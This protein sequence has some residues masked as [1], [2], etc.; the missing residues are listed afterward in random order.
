MS[1]TSFLE[2]FSL[3][4]GEALAEREQSFVELRYGIASGE[5]YTLEQVAQVFSLS[6]ER[7]RQVLERSLRKIKHRGRRDLKQGKTTG[8]CAA[9]LGYAEQM[10]KPDEQGDPERIMMFAL[11]ELPYLP[12]QTYAFPL[13]LSLL[14]NEADAKPIMTELMRIHAEATAGQ[15]HHAKVEKLARECTRLLSDTLWPRHIQKG[16][17]RLHNFIDTHLERTV[18][19]DSSGNAGSFLSQ[20]MNRE[21]AYRSQLEMQML[22][23]LEAAEEVEWYQEQPF[24][25]TEEAYGAKRTCRPDI[26]FVL[27]DGRGAIAEVNLWTHMALQKNLI[28]YETLRIFCV[29][30]GLGLLIT[31]GR[32]TFQQIKQHPIPLT[33]Q[34]ALLD[35]ITQSQTKSLT[36]KEYQAIR[37]QYAASWMDFLAIIRANKLIWSLQPFTLKKSDR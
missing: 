1:D 28:K 2:L 19:A 3:A 22:Q 11:E 34:R 32:K 30:N 25:V 13:L 37:D 21:I 20:K 12:Q 6:R 18:P 26:L 15:R 29:K 36:W 8:A 35:A 9:L 14:F 5:P 10:C 23:R 33:F 4:L 27:K 31:D 17:D 16:M 7:I 24:L